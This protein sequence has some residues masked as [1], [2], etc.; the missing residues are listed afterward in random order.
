MFNVDWKITIEGEKKYKL[1]FLDSVEITE[2]V[3]VLSD[4][5][6]I[7]IPGSMLN[8]QL[9]VESKVK[10]GDRVTIELGYDGDLKTEFK[11]FLRSISTDDGS[12]TFNCEDGIYLTRKSVKDKEFKNCTSKDVAQYVVDQVNASL[13]ADG[14]IKLVCDWEITYEKF[15]IVKANGYDVLNKLQEE[16]KGN[17]YM[18]GSELHYHPSYVEKF[19]EARY[20]FSVNIEKSEL[21]YRKADEKS[22]EVVIEATSNDGKKVSVTAGTTGGEKRTIVKA[23]VF[24]KQT[25]KK[26]AEDE[27]KYLVFDGYEGSFTGWLVPVC[28][29]GYSASIVDKEYDY[30]S[31]TYYVVSVVTSASSSGASRKIELGRKLS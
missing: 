17:I 14:K 15:V 9:E 23:G 22:I 1:L 24:D 6:K 31:G 30:K 28:H 21:K 3:D 8:K 13:P 19:G 20:D 16:T 25:L 29:A 10:A 4:T 12:L 18:K 11:G 26:L 2:S 7:K 27:L 5:A